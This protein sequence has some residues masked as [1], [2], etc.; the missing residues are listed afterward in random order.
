MNYRTQHDVLMYWYLGKD[1]EKKD[2][3]VLMELKQWSNE[4][5]YDCENE[6]N[7]V[8]DFFGKRE[9]PHPSLQVEGYHFDLQDFLL[10]LV[11]TMLPS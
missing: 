11:V 6:G 8:V 1:N 7:V 9:M 4:H 2:A 10:I 3:V 5:V